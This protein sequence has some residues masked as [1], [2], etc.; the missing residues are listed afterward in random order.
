MLE[1]AEPQ[2]IFG[3]GT[4]CEFH[5][6]SDVCVQSFESGSGGQ[7]GD[8]VSFV[9]IQVTWLVCRSDCKGKIRVKVWKSGR[10]DRC[11]T[12]IIQP[13]VTLSFPSERS[14]A[15]LCLHLLLLFPGL[16]LF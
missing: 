12:S 3:Q 8:P 2:N 7:I 1:H 10:N 4:Q 14:A 15:P 9:F 13:L 5:S 11:R 6:D 16:N